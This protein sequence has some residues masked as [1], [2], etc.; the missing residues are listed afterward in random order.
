[1]KYSGGDGEARGANFS[2]L[3]KIFRISVS[4]RKAESKFSA[5]H[6]NLFETLGSSLIFARSHVSV[7]LVLPTLKNTTRA[8]KANGE[9]NRIRT[10]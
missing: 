5:R 3:I 8:V 10:R 2:K 7:R 4:A 1:M 6:F 9:S